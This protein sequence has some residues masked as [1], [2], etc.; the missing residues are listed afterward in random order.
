MLLCSVRQRNPSRSP[1]TR[2]PALATSAVAAALVDQWIAFQR[3]NQR[4][5]SPR[6]SHCRRAFGET[7]GVVPGRSFWSIRRY[8]LEQVSAPE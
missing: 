1:T 2:D 4:W 7:I 6:F 5:G 8:L 3:E